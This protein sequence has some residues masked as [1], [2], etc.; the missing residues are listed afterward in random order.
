M[1]QEIKSSLKVQRGRRPADQHIHRYSDT[2][3]AHTSQYRAYARQAGTDI[4]AKKKDSMSASSGVSRSGKTSSPP[5]KRS[6]GRPPKAGPRPFACLVK[7]CGLTYSARIGLHQHRRAKHPELITPR[8]SAS[9]LSGNDGSARRFRCLVSGCNK[10]YSTSAGL[11][12]H[13][14]HKHPEL[15]KR[16]R[17]LPAK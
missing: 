13:K 8:G 15:I 3:I 10:G 9:T 16:R 2:T 6:L 5:K 17:C 7:G 12:Q 1:D 14:N 4:M 11:Y